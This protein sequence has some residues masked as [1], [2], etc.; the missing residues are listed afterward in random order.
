M[1]RGEQSKLQLPVGVWAS[2]VSHLL[3]SSQLDVLEDFRGNWRGGINTRLDM[4]LLPFLIRLLSR[5]LLLISIRRDPA[6]T[7]PMSK[8]VV[9][10]FLLL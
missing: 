7:H 4:E 9:P 1:E 8:P 10:L 3:Q 5:F 6:R 2:G